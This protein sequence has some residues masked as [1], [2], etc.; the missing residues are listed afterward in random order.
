ML[1]G[2]IQV[3]SKVGLGSTFTVET[4]YLPPEFLGK[5]E[6]E[7]DLSKFSFSPN[8]KV[9]AVEDNPLNQKMLEILFKELG[10]QLIITENGKDGVSKTLELKPDLVLM[11]LHM[12]VMDG[13]EATKIIR[14]DSTC[15]DIPIV[16]VTANVLIDQKQKAADLGIQDFLLKPIDLRKLMQVLSKYLS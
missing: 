8:S 2:N 1:N 15:K 3:E 10:V 6:I 16:V 4:S 13:Y 5:P 9:V 14:N 7:I 11:D 12:P